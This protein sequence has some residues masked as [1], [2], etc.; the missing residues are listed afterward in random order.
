KVEL[1]KE[2][3]AVGRVAFVGDGV[4]DAAALA[5]ASVGVAMGV[6]GSD[7]ALEAADVA[8]LSDDLAKLPEAHDL[9][10]RAN[11]VIRQNLAFALGIMLVMVLAT[12]FWS[13][14]LPLG[15]L[16]HEG[17]TILVVMNGLRLL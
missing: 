15:V 8:L 4:N 10:R 2:F 17:G 6:A 3:A 1:V 13:L 9:A 16:G 14:P 11:L 5:T 12:L 7:A